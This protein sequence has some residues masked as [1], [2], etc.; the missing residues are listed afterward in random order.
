M[1]V[2]SNVEC[3]VDY[4]I[5]TSALILE[6]EVAFFTDDDSDH[7]EVFNDG[8]PVDEDEV[9]NAG[10]TVD[11]DDALVYYLIL[12]GVLLVLELLF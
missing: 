8:N 2:S 11:E 7:V 6:D 1:R 12:L 10:N 9:F 5:D 3:Y 4:C